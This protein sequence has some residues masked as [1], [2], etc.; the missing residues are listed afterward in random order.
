MKINNSYMEITVFAHSILAQ[1]THCNT[2]IHNW[3]VVPSWGK[4]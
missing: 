2:S 4:W 3:R 1:I